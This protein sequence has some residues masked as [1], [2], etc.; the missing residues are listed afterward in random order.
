MKLVHI[1][2]VSVLLLPWCLSGCGKADETPPDSATE[3]EALADTEPVAL[4]ELQYTLYCASCHGASGAGDGPVADAL[5]VRPTNL[6]L[7]ES[8]NEGVFPTDR[9]SSYIDGREYV[10]AHGSRVMPVWGNVWHQGEGGEA[11]SEAE[12]QRRIAELVEYIRSIQE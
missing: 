6:T 3:S 8:I 7:L 1:L 9:L 4:G 10:A 5:K 12:V 11:L 2:V